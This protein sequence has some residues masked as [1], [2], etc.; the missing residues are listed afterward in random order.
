MQGGKHYSKTVH[1]DQPKIK[2]NLLLGPHS[3]ALVFQ[4]SLHFIRDHPYHQHQFSV[5]VFIVIYQTLFMQSLLQILQ[6][7]GFVNK[8]RFFNRDEVKYICG[9]SKTLKR[10]IL[11]M[12]TEEKSYLVFCFLQ[13]IFAYQNRYCLLAEKKYLDILLQG[14]QF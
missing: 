14:Q 6:S 12:K 1:K 11:T 7:Y 10:C 3:H 4:V 5:T 8:G 2:T 9:K 13:R